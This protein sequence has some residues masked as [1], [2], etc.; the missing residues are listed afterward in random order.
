MKRLTWALV[1][2]AGLALVTVVDFALRTQ[3][4]FATADTPAPGVVFTGQFNRVHA[5]LALLEQGAVSPLLISGTNPPAG[6]PLEDFAQQ[7][8]LSNKLQEALAKGSLV[9]GADAHNTFENAAETQ[10]WLA[11]LPTHSPIVLVTSR[12]HAPRIAGSGASRSWPDRAARQRAR[13]LHVVP[14]CIDG[15]GK[16]VWTRVVGAWLNDPDG[17]G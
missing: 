4:T 10:R 11:T 12:P 7:F 15:V 9:L 16:F 1:L 6:I 8:Q 3:S 2:M 17:Q 13:G 5:G 14:W